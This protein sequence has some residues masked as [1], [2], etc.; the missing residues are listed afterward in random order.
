VTP[1]ETLG[2][3]TTARWEVRTDGRPAG[4]LDLELPVRFALP[5]GEPGPVTVVG[6]AGPGVTA[7]T[8]TEAAVLTPATP[9]VRRVLRASIDCAALPHPL[10]DDAYGLTVLAPGTGAAPGPAVLAPAPGLPAGPATWSEQ[11]RDGCAG[12]EAAAYLT[13]SAVSADVSP[14]VPAV[15][16]AATVTNDGPRPAVLERPAAKPT[17][18][19]P[20]MSAARIVV[21]PGASAVVRLQQRFDPC[22][23]GYRFL[24]LQP[25]SL[26]LLGLVGFVGQTAADPTSSPTSVAVPVAPG[27]AERVITAFAASCGG[28]QDVLA[29]TPPGSFSYEGGRVT[30]RMAIDVTPGAVVRLRLH[31]PFTR[32]W[33]V[34]PLGPW[35]VPDASGQVTTQIV[36]RRT[37][38]PGACELPASL[39]IDV[40]PRDARRGVLTFSTYTLPQGPADEAAAQCLPAPGKG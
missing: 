20:G 21:D 13:V 17:P 33:D 30:V 19:E 29:L 8:L 7:S 11:V 18:E 26:A 25:D 31:P 5:D 23:A 39:G 15:S 37:G 28:V 6:L 40:V 10:P 36:Y 27:V 4:P 22:G 3:P 24:P 14:D 9:V 34:A 38:G 32:G 12:W 1:A 2:A 35:L 16:L